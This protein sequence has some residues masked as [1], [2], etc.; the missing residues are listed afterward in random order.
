VLVPIVPSVA[1]RRRGHTACPVW[2]G[3]VDL[4]DLGRIFGMARR[5]VG[6]DGS[7]VHLGLGVVVGDD[8]EGRV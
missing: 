4:M 3:G 7:V 6:G 5:R 2:V 8:R 1:K